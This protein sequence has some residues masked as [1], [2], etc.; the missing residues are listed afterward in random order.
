VLASCAADPVPLVAPNAG[1][2][3]SVASTDTFVPVDGGYQRV[4]PV[5]TD[6]CLHY[7]TTMF[8]ADM[9]GAS[10]ELEFETHVCNACETPV[11]IDVFYPAT[12]ATPPTISTQLIYSIGLPIGTRDPHGVTYLG[13]ECG[14]RCTYSPVHNYPGPIVPVRSLLAAG[15]TEV[16][17]QHARKL[18]LS[19]TDQ[20]LREPASGWTLPDYSG[21]LEG[22]LVYPRARSATSAL[23]LATASSLTVLC[24][25]IGLAYRDDLDGNQRYR[26]GELG[27]VEDLYIIRSI[28]PLRLPEKT[29]RFLRSLELRACDN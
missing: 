13:M 26:R 10:P 23:S 21:E 20:S 12:P 4:F 28:G 8:V 6:G 7:Q 24:K 11:A 17:S 5:V 22:L 29:M 3:A 25:S 18:A 1:P 27:K 19:V 2:C 9:L 15:A 16:L 14:G